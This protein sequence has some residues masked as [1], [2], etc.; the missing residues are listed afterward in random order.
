MKILHDITTVNSQTATSEETGYLIDN[1]VDYT[2][3]KQWRSTS[4]V[5]QTIVLNFTG[6]IDSIAI[7]GANFS[8]ITVGGVVKTLIKD[9]LIGDYRGY[10]STVATSSL[11]LIVTAQTA[12]DTYF[13]ISALVV[14]DETDVDNVVYPFGMQLVNPTYKTTNDSGYPA[15][16]AKGEN[17]RL[18]E[19]K[20]DNL[21]YSDIE[22]LAEIK[23]SVKQG[24]TFVLFA[25]DS[26]AG[27]C[28]L[29]TRVDR[30]EYTELSNDFGNDSLILEETGG[31]PYNLRSLVEI[32]LDASTLYYSTETLKFPI[33]SPESYKRR[34]LSAGTIKDA[35]QD[36]F[37]QFQSLSTT[38]ITLD[39]LD[40][41][42]KDIH[43]G[44]NLRGKSVLIKKVDLDSDTELKSVAFTVESVSFT[45]EKATI[46]L[47]R[48]ELDI[49][50]VKHPKNKFNLTDYPNIP[51]G[52][53]I[54]D[55][56]IPIYYGEVKFVPCFYIEAAYTPDDYVYVIQGA[57]SQAVDNVYRDG[58]LVDGGEYSTDLDASGVTTITFALEQKNFQGGLY[59]ITADIKGC[60]PSGTY[61]TNPVTCF[62][63]WLE[64]YVGV[65]CYATSFTA[66]ETIADS[67]NLK[68]G[69]GLTTETEAIDLREQWKLACRC[70]EFT[71]GA[72]GWEIVIPEYESTADADFTDS[73][74]DITKYGES[75]ASAF[76]NNVTVSYYYDYKEKTYLKTNAKSCS[77]AYGT[78]KEYKLLLVNDDETASRITQYIRNSFLYGDETLEA[79]TGRDGSELLEGNVLGITA[80]KPSLSDARYRIKTI[81]RNKSKVS[82]FLTSYSTNIFTWVDDSADYQASPPS[83][84]A[85]TAPAT[86]AAFATANIVNG[87]KLTWTHNTES[88]LKEYEIYRNTA[89]YKTTKTNIYYDMTEAYSTEYTYKIRAKN[90]SDQYSGFSGNETGTAQKATEANNI[91]LNY[92]TTTLN[93][94]ITTNAGN[95][96][97]RVTQT[98]YEDLDGVSANTVAR[99]VNASSITMTPANITMTSG[100]ITLSSTGKIYINTATGLEI[101]GSGKVSL[102]ANGQLYF[103]GCCVFDASSTVMR[104]YPST[105]DTKLLFFGGSSTNW[106]DIYGYASNNITFGTGND[107]LVT[108]HGEAYM[109]A[110]ENLY[111]YSNENILIKPGSGAGEDIYMKLPAS[112]GGATKNWSRLY[113]DPLGY[114]KANLDTP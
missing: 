51:D 101:G 1:A 10:F 78:D 6:S 62:K 55:K 63:H 19:I 34:L 83:Q 15:K 40:S 76:V 60:K 3:F 39:D 106:L 75:K 67:L 102:K 45:Q 86:P 107:F 18:I 84:E 85:A 56:A 14:G 91:T 96:T 74:L 33:S 103:N 108:A 11:T 79:V 54:L 109:S 94:R 36:N 44:E 48:S 41:A 89:Y 57:V 17:Y 113:R 97:L 81:S 80:T 52:A 23:Q 73:N 2:N 20:R 32:T 58:V 8:S 5:Q 100:T 9:D 88:N 82:L 69:G 49:W 47:E 68:V 12:D 87:I 21:D 4:K 30:F 61:S 92:G 24:Q 37:S 65:T 27:E 53:N 98:D 29:G 112:A 26:D 22:G 13:K 38:T 66:A 25:D 77:K 99:K 111:L 59:T 31:K 28:Y 64:T 114:V 16:I 105:A 46:G 104:I 43:D 71:K 70:A 35:L 72:S 90:N 50:H 7:F 110:I 95:I 93:S 42:I